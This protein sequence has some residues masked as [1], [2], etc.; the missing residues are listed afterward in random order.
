MSGERKKP[1]DLRSHRRFGV[2]DLRSFGHRSRALQFGY[3]R[4]VFAGKPVIGII[5]GTCV[6]H[7]VPESFVGGPLA[8]VRDGDLIELG[9]ER[10]RLDLKVSEEE[11]ARRRAAWQP[12]RAPYTR[13]YGALYA[14][15]I[16]HADKG[17]DFDFL[18]FGPPTPDPEIH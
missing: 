10:R 18:H 12:P 15:H 14:R 3:A 6:L 7:V 11:L 4:E 1:E 5:Y 2:K 9:V 16:T 8:L 17:C 13:G